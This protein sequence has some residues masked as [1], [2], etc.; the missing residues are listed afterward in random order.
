MKGVECVH[1]TFDLY[2]C[3]PF[4]KNSEPRRA[5]C[6]SYIQAWRI[7]SYKLWAVRHMGI[8]D[9]SVERDTRSERSADSLHQ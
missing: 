5:C 6:M 2:T 1:R 4:R 9:V 7:S 8:A 3:L